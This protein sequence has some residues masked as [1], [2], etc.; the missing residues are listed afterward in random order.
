MAIWQQIG[1]EK[2]EFQ[3]QWEIIIANNR[4][5]TIIKEKQRNKNN[6]Y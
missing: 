6:S 5:I 1:K 4:I 2:K 3:Q